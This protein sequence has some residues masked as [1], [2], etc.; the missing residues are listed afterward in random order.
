MSTIEFPL[1]AL[2]N[3]IVAAQASMRHPRMDKG[4]QIFEALTMILD[5]ATREAM[6]ELR[7]VRDIRARAVEMEM[8]LMAIDERFIDGEDTF[9]DWRFMGTAAREALARIDAK[10]GKP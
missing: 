1:V 9:D 7:D 8:A 6:R 4:T 3:A 2:H 5:A 10:G